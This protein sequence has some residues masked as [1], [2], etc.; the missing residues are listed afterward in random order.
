MAS[1][2]FASQPSLFVWHL[3][4]QSST[5]CMPLLSVVSLFFLMYR[6]FLD[7]WHCNRC[8]QRKCS[9]ESEEKNYISLNNRSR[10]SHLRQ[11]PGCIS[12]DYKSLSCSR[13]TLASVGRLHADANTACNS[14]QRI[15]HTIFGVGAT[16]VARAMPAKQHVRNMI[17]SL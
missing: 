5:V 14:W 17:A 6:F 12:R 4:R 15:S 9:E 16:L 1:L 3:S 7:T 13:R 2:G 11:V 10:L 8:Q